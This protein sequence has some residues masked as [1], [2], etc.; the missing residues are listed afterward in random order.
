M[1]GV[2]ASL[3]GVGQTTTDGNGNYSFT[4]NAPAN[5]TVSVTPP[6]GYDCTTPCQLWTPWAAGRS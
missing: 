4:A 6:S 2:T 1:P 3:S 5:Y